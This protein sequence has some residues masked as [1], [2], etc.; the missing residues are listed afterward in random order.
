MCTV[1]RL[2][3]KERVDAWYSAITSITTQTSSDL[4]LVLTSGPASNCCDGWSMT[5]FDT[6]DTNEA[7]IPICNVTLDSWVGST[8]T[9]DLNESCGITVTTSDTVMVTPRTVT[10]RFAPGAGSN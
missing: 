3:T 6:S 2:V 8:K 1:I 9:I 5:V 10:D 7:D 4:V